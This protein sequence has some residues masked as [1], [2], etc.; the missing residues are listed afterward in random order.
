M[1]R[2]TQDTY[3][4]VSRALHWLMAL[5]IIGML[6]VGFVM[7]EFGRD[8]PLRPL[9]YSL[10]KS[11]GTLLLVL[12]GVRLLWAWL[13]QKPRPLGDK[14]LPNHVAR[15]VHI[16]LYLLMI[17]LPLSGY[18][19]VASGTSSKPFEFFGLFALPKVTPSN[20]LHETAEE[21]HGD[22]PWFAVA[23]I[24]LHIAGGLKRHFI[25]RDGTLARMWRS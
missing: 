15:L 3:G 23:L 4:S 13:N 19:L 17:G 16:G 11:T 2:N 8:D 6:L 18:L 25:E 9:L 5:L 20:W 21:L 14:M 7:V 10:H 12:I 24:G 1:L 22:L